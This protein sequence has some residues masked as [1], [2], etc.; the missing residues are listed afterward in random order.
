MDARFPIKLDD[1]CFYFSIPFFDLHLKCVFCN[2][3]L[4]LQELA[5]FYEKGLSLI[6]RRNI[7]FAC[8][9]KCIQ[10][11]AKFEKENYFVCCVTP[12]TLECMLTKCL[13]DINI[14]CMLCLRKLDYAEKIDH[15]VKDEVFC[16]IRGYWRGYCRFCMRKE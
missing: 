5:D 1:Y 16:L 12:T 15:L 4:T 8:C 3:Y 6:W 7:C 10:L 9:R 2:F 13:K 11:S 14:R